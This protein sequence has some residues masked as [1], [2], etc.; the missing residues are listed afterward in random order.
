[1][2]HLVEAK[3]L[4]TTF[5]YDGKK[6]RLTAVDN[7][8][9]YLDKGEIVGL[10]GESGSGKSVTTMSIL[11]LILPPGKIEGE[12]N[13][14]GMKGNILDYGMFSD[15]ARGIR[16]GRIGMIFQEP[17]TSLNPIL[18]VGYQIQE[19]IM[20]HLGLDEKAAKVKAI[21]MMKRVGIANAEERFAQYPMQFSGGMRQDRK[22][23]V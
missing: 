10:V 13:V 21:E 11:Q 7:V 4:V 1:M 16:G 8:S 5:P 3:N 23:V 14:E 18:T 15:E 9:L 17:M 22:S 20:T 6:K 2:S 19:N 12:V